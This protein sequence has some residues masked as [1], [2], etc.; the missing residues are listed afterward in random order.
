[1]AIKLW[2]KLPAQCR[3]VPSLK[4]FKSN[5]SKSVKETNVLYYY[6]HRWAGIHHARLRIGCSK[7]KH[8]LYHNLHVIDSPTCTCGAEIEDATHF[9]LYCPNYDELRETLYEKLTPFRAF[10][11]DAILHGDKDLA[12]ESNQV[13][14]DAVHQFICDS[15]RFI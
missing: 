15:G 10:N 7:L 12:V 8:D 14:F 1:M 2:N 4:S 6:G 5:L 9:F 13:V 3:N 11:I